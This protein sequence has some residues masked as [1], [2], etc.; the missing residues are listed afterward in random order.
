MTDF[1]L[2]EVQ[3]G[4]FL[5]GENKPVSSR[6]LQRWRQKN[7]G[8]RWCRIGRLVRYRRSALDAYLDANTVEPIPER[9]G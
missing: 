4:R 2:D 5:G 3:A 6:T 8:P 7:L 9:D 1:L